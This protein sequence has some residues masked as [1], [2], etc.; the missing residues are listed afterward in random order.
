MILQPT[1]VQLTKIRFFDEKNQNFIP[2]ISR[3]VFDKT[4]FNGNIIKKNNIFGHRWVLKINEIGA[5]NERNG[6]KLFI[7]ILLFSG[8]I[9]ALTAGLHFLFGNLSMKE[10]KSL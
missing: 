3:Q 10:N 9:I 5:E 8:I 4:S 6:K 7:Y 1:T 2:S